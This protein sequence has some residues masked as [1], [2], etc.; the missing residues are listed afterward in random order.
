MRELDQVERSLTTART[1]LARSGS[2]AGSGSTSIGT[3]PEA[4]S[5]LR[6]LEVQVRRLKAQLADEQQRNATAAEEIADLRGQL[7]KSQEVLVT[8]AQRARE[9][10]E[11]IAMAAGRKR[12]ARS[13]PGHDDD[14]Q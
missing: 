14:D 6:E 10:R 7:T 2:G 9:D 8:F 3:S 13:A 11:E 1:G 5:R 12:M 4:Q